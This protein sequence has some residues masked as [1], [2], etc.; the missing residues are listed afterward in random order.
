MNRDVRAMARGD[1][2]PRGNPL[3]HPVREAVVVDVDPDKK[4]IKVELMPEGAVLP[5]MK[6]KPFALTMGA[7]TGYAMPKNGQTVLLLTKDPVARAYRFLC[8]VDDQ[9]EQAVPYT[10]GQIV[11][12]HT[13]GNQLLMDA[14]GTVYIGKKDGAEGLLQASWAT[15]NHDTHTHPHPMGPTSTPTTP[16]S[17]HFTTKSKGA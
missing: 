7:W 17:G 1:H 5:W 16:A 6:C 3:T 13:N 14:D 8:V 15:S 4:A 11:F 2:E 9:D 10:P 12:T